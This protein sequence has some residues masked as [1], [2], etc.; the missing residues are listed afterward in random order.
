M[1]GPDVDILRRV[2]VLWDSVADR[3]DFP[4]SL[5]AVR[6]LDGLRFSAPVT[7][8]VGDNGSGK[9]TVVEA[10]AMA[11]GLSP[12]GGNR[13]IR[14]EARDSESSLDGHLRLTYGTRPAQSFF[15]RG[16]TWFQAG[17]AY[18][19]LMR[20]EGGIDQRS[21]GEGFIEGVTS[22]LFGPRGLYFMDEPESGLSVLGLLQLLR[23]VHQLVAGASQ[24]VIAT[25]SPVLLAFPGAVILEL[26]GDGMSAVGYDDTQVVSLTRSFL[27][28]PER[29]LRPLLED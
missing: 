27:E 4:F 12:G 23:V 6:A 16:E 28:A 5:P 20:I 29:F 1:A 25:H 2:D 22:R 8:L 10:L 9:S 15:V 24:L 14:V 11:A 13:D 7:F 3:D 17:G 19:G 18:Q 21:H 26:D